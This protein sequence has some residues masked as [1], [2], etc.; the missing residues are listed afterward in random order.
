M[1][2]NVAR[3]NGTAWSS[4]GSGAANGVDDGVVALAIASNGDVYV[5]GDFTRAGG[6]VAASI[7]RWNG[8]M[9]SSLGSGIAIGTFR[10]IP[11]SLL[12]LT[13]KAGSPKNVML[14]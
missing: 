1:A 5:G 2:G 10:A 14:G 7:A 4:L 8:T 12:G 6:T 9:W 13:Q 11:K 3:W